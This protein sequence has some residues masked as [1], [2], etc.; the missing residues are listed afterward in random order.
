MVCNMTFLIYT[1]FTFLTLNVLVYNNYV[2]E[3]WN[4]QDYDVLQTLR[5]HKFQWRLV[6]LLLRHFKF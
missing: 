6:G 1:L 2:F 4:E 3:V 5:N